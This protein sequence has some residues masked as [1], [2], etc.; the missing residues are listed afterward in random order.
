VQQINSLETFINN[1]CFQ[2]NNDQFAKLRQ[3]V[4]NI[5]APFAKFIVKDEKVDWKA[6]LINLLISSIFFS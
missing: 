1:I 6:R 5:L 3:Q 2:T 4:K